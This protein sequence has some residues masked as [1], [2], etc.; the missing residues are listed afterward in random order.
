[1]V[2]VISGDTIKGDRFTVAPPPQENK[3]RIS[4][5]ANLYEVYK[6]Y[7]NTD[8]DFETLVDKMTEQY[9]EAEKATKNEIFK[10]MTD[11]GTTL[12]DFFEATK[13]QDNT[14]YYLTRIDDAT[15]KDRPYRE[16]YGMAMVYR[17]V[18]HVDDEKQAGIEITGEVMKML[19]MTESDLYE[20]G[21]KNTAR[22]LEPR[23]TASADFIEKQ[24]IYELKKHGAPQEIAETIAAMRKKEWQCGMK[25]DFYIISSKWGNDGALFGLDKSVLTDIADQVKDDL[26]VI[27]PTK[28]EAIASRATGNDAEGLKS[29]CDSG[30]REILSKHKDANNMRCTDSVFYFN[31]TDKEIT[32]IA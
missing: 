32:V 31:R 8:V 3:R 27:F 4:P 11:K 18:L 12:K 17:L 13:P 25:E 14:I 20:A 19:K 6:V 16:Y 30:Y 5:A 24:A 1:T 21:Q 26:I 22:I 15:L 23:F 9:I 28:D 7:E 10:K 2:M 29:I